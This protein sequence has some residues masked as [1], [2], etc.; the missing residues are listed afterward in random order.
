MLKGSRIQVPLIL[1]INNIEGK[2]LTVALIHHST[3]SNCVYP[4]SGVDIPALKYIEAPL[5]NT[6]SSIKLSFFGVSCFIAVCKH[7][8]SFFYHNHAFSRA[9]GGR[10][11]V[12]WKCTASIFNM[13]ALLCCVWSPAGERSCSVGWKKPKTFYVA[14]LHR[15]VY[16]N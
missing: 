5:L 14:R 11:M 12:S 4:L 7:I 10:V 8:D 3:P 15:V 1:Y 13:R 9:R 6:Y 2:L 16:D